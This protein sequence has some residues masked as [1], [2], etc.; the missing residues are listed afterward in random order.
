MV[1]NAGESERGTSPA[2]A[3]IDD[4]AV[5]LLEDLPDLLL[6]AAFGRVE[7]APRVHLEKQ[8]N[9]DQRCKS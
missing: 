7:K 1:S 5:F 4:D 8:R 3:A 9:N 2:G 6:A